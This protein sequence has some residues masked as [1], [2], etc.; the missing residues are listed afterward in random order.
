MPPGVFLVKVL[1]VKIEFIA[2]MLEQIGAGM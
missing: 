2:P 1:S